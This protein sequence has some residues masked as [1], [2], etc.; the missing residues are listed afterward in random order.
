VLDNIEK[1][2]L[3]KKKL[4]EALQHKEDIMQNNIYRKL[5]YIRKML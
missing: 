3:W 2:P 5:Y 1:F 4:Q